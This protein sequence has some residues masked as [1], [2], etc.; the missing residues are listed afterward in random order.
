[1]SDTLHIVCPACDA[2]NRI[3]VARLGEGPKCGKCH[4]PLFAGHPTELTAARFQQ[5]IDRS[6]IPVLVDF[7]APWCAPCRM[8]APAF[9]QAAAQLEPRVRLTKVDTES[10]QALGARYGIRSI[11]TLALFKNGREIARQPGAMGAADIVRWT[12]GHL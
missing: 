5:H 11:P 8:M 3:P 6:D 7:W 2:V 4:A 12:L 1:M 10:E 9:Q